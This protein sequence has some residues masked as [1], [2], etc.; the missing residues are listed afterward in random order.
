M[1]TQTEI[2]LCRSSYAD[3]VANN[4]KIVEHFYDRLFEVA[5]GVRDM[6]P[7]DM[8]EQSGKLRATLQVAL[9]M[10]SYPE[11]LLPILHEFGRKHAEYGA[12]PDHYQVVG[13][14]LIDT[15]A[16]HAGEGWTEE[17][18][19][20]WQTLIGGIAREMI[21]AAQEVEIKKAS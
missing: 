8:A 5:P 7:A 14:V 21:A 16:R 9:N 11:E 17:T 10:L 2:D 13:E 3:V 18:S 4:S 20:A 6:F 19:V 12:T 1:L 15:L